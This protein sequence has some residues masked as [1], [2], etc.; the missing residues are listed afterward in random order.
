MGFLTPPSRHL[1]EGHMEFS[2]RKVVWWGIGIFGVITSWAFLTGIWSGV[3]V[4]YVLLVSILLGAL[5]GGL[6]S[7]LAYQDGLYGSYGSIRGDRK[8]SNEA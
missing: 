2:K 8:T 4:G 5:V 3:P 1:G 7:V 6:A